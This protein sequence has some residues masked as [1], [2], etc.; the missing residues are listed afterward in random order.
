MVMADPGWWAL[1]SLAVGSGG[2]RRLDRGG[3]LLVARAPD[4]P[5]RPAAHQQAV[6]VGNTSYYWA[7]LLLAFAVRLVA[8]RDTPLT[9]LG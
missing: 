6:A 9:A 1:D 8:V 4:A 5:R 7:I 3:R 2:C